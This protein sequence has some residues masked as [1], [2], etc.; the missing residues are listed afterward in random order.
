MRE[1]MSSVL[2]SLKCQL[3][4]C[5]ETLHLV[6]GYSNYR[7]WS[8]VRDKYLAITDLYLLDLVRK[9]S[10]MALLSVASVGIEDRL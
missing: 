3:D 5:V 8:S 6:I 2:L 7:L 10:V 4:I 1:I 9:I